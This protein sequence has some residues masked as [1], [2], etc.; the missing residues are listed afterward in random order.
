MS[1]LVKMR[2]TFGLV[3]GPK[4]GFGLSGDVQQAMLTLRFAELCGF[5]QRE[6]HVARIACIAAFASFCTESSSE[7]GA[8]VLAGTSL[9]LRRDV[10]CDGQSV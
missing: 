3:G 8:L 5:L 6:D 9:P 10:V 2:R 1:E 4:P 7:R